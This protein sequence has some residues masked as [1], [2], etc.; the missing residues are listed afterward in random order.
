[1]RARGVSLSG[2]A[3]LAGAASAAARRRFAAKTLGDVRDIFAKHRTLGLRNQVLEARHR[4]FLVPLLFEDFKA[5][6]RP[7]HVGVDRERVTAQ[8]VLN[9]VGNGVLRRAEPLEMFL[10][11]LE[12][13]LVQ[14]L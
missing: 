6:E 2:G 13:L 8:P 7:L 3:Q 12:A 11:L 10:S 1:M 9:G 4:R 5:N 14:R